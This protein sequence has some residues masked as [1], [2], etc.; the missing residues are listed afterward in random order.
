MDAHPAD[1]LED[2]RRLD[3]LRRTG[4]LDT[5]CEDSFDRVTHLAAMVLRTPMALTSLV[6][7]QR[8]FCKSSV[9]LPEPY[10]T[11]CHIPLSHSFCQHVVRTGAPLIVADA[12]VH[13]L[14][15]SNPAVTEFKAI[16]YLGVPLTSSEGD[17]LGSLC[18]IGSDPREW[19]D[20]DL[21][22]LG[23]LGRL[24]ET[25]ITCRDGVRARTSAEKE[26]RA[27]EEQLRLA[28]LSCRI[29]T[30]HVNMVDRSIVMS[31]Q[32]R[33]FCHLG[34]E[35]T[36]TPEWLEARVDPDDRE[37]VREAFR[38]LV[39]M[40][41]DCH[42]EFRVHPVEGKTRWI[43]AC[44]R[45]F[46]DGSGRPM[47]IDGIAIDVSD[48]KH[49]EENALRRAEQLRRLV[50]GSIRINAAHDV[51]S[52]LEAVV[53]EA[54]ILIG[55]E[56][57][58]ARIAPDQNLIRATNVDQ[59][60]SAGGSAIDALVRTTKRPVRRDRH[61]GQVGAGSEASASLRDDDETPESGIMVVP[62]LGRG[63]TVLGTISLAEKH[64]GDFTDEDQSLL[65]QLAHVA[66]TALENARLY[67][68]L[69]E[70][71]RRKDEFLAVLAHELRN[72]LAA[73]THAVALIRRNST[74]P[75]GAAWSMEVIGRQTGNL[76]RMVN[77]LLDVSRITR[78][79]VDL[80]MEDVSVDSLIAHVE[81]AILPRV[82]ERR[83][84]FQVV[85]PRK[86][87]QIIKAD[88][89][90]IEQVLLNLLSNAT[91]FTPEQGRIVF[92][93]RRDGNEMVFLVSDNGVGIR[94][95]ILPRIFELFVQDA[96]ILAR[97]QGGLGI[98][99]TIV[100]RLVQLHGGRIEA[101]S[102]GL[103]CGSEFEVRLP[104]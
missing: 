34:D 25:E 86:R 38:Q 3:A 33:S 89:I 65:E 19:S 55:A 9:G 85:R 72:P 12:R 53:D 59:P 71:D 28:S 75:E 84:E 73:L 68:M 74:I 31:E 77:E 45:C 79:L 4:L 70:N 26:L 23:D 54:K 37:R 35:Q 16:A 18:V 95:E 14:L 5:P 56:T 58:V 99:L 40:N 67:H 13:P 2:P 81:E 6:D 36:P 60:A 88:A 1:L 63:E 91:K 78:G 10:A 76:T 27:S 64:D 87:L 90:R 7:D 57:C 48:R 8:E 104:L 69:K 62:M 61:P 46:P 50:A 30:W 20:A 52:V 32:C 21:K 101:R 49:S 83:Q 39:E 24:V 42:V 41:D 22:L 93:I 80:R 82:K 44:G 98:G 103:G 92:T 15:H 66:S 17:V 11:T 29:G 47:F 102:G 100:K 96:G 97:V 43:F 94:A 51:D